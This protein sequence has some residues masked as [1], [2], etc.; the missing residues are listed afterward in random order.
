M[1]FVFTVLLC[2]MAG[3]LPAQSKL[4]NQGKLMLLP[5]NTGLSLKGA[6]GRMRAL[7]SVR[8]CGCDSTL[9]AAG[10]QI[11]GR[12]G[13]IRSVSLLPGQWDF[14]LSSPCIQYLDPAGRANS[15]RFRNDT[16]RS[17]SAV[18]KV[19]NGTN[20]GLPQA[21]TGKGV[22]VG[23]VDIGFQC[24][25]PTFYSRDGSKLRISRIWLQA[26]NAGNAP[27]GF[28]YGSEYTDSLSISGINDMDGTHGTH[29]AGIAGG[30]GYSTPGLRY[31]GMAPESELVFVSI[32]YAND[33]LPGSALGDYLVA[34]PAILD[35]YRYIFD[36]A[37]SVGRPAVINLSWGMHTG[38]HDGTSLF[39]L[40]TESLS[41]KG[42]ILVGANGNDGENPMHLSHNF[43]GD[44]ISS[45]MIENG[46]Q[47]RSGESV[48]GDFWGSAGSSFSVKIRFI[49]TLKQTMAETP[50]FS[51]LSDTALS[52][53]LVADS[54]E[55]KVYL[56]A[57]AANPLNGKPNITVMAEHPNQ[58]KYAILVSLT[59]AASTVHGWNSGAARS[60]TSGSF[61]NRLNRIDI[62]GLKS[63]NS[64]Y[65]A[66]ENGG[67]SKAVISVGAVAARTAYTNING[68]LINDSG[69]TQPYR[70]APFSS[71]GPTVDG[72][73]KPDICA[74]GFDV[75]SSVNNKQ[76]AD[77]MKDRTVLK[78][79]F[80][81]D[82]QYWTCFNGT[83]MAAPHATGIAAL[84][85]QINPGLSPAEIRDILTRT[86]TADAFTGTVPNN[87]Y[88]YGR[89]NAY[90]A[91]LET[92]RYTGLSASHALGLR[93]G[94]NP[95]DADLTVFVPEHLSGGTLYW[96]GTD[97]R[98]LYSGSLSAG[99][100]AVPAGIAQ[101][102]G[103]YLLQYCAGGQTFSF[104]VLKN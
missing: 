75:P 41:G 5:E 53:R 18:D 90:A 13:Q 66:G 12:Y 7:V 39:D 94:P 43:N 46:R 4:S 50:Y 33:T 70:L 61:R 55:F 80:N 101:N 30:S 71:R 20:F 76:F 93:V 28:A 69:Y 92:L 102:S 56:A 48:Y 86:A 47:W 9:S 99:D 8:D 21:Y 64:D 14:L 62:A 84:L 95:F 97:G 96:Y 27:S 63:G 31:A 35:A 45:I 77:W 23:I 85:L 104:K 65:T 100:N 52:F 44:T 26:S 91:V 42:K 60:W 10:I 59:S 15:A 68:K 58:R 67:S 49:D 2:L 78:S 51:S 36:Y 19:H 25:N 79:V 24:N 54:S 74:P 87:A 37:A 3:T 88:G 57:E 73:T 38:P 6:D 72:R 1:K 17:F 82:T 83:S 103:L 32:K 98:L 29:V 22:V 34:N 89:I 11:N 81:G 16:E 40:A